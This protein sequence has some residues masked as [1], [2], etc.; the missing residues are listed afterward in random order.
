MAHRPVR[1]G[2]STAL[3]PFTAEKGDFIAISLV[4]LT[5]FKDEGRLAVEADVKKLFKFF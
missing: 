1:F 3:Y 5:G 2:G 4:R